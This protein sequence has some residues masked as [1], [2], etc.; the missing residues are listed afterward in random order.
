MLSTN[1][2]LETQGTNFQTVDAT[3]YALSLTASHA[4]HF[5][6]Q[7]QILG[8]KAD[9]PIVNQFTGSKATSRANQSGAET[10]FGAHF[11]DNIS[12]KVDLSVVMFLLTVST[13]QLE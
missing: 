9:V 2:L 3:L 13:N 5:T 4:A 10:A 6:N 12:P 8:T 7:Y 11:C 1:Q